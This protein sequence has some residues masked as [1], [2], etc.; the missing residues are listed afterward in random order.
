MNTQYPMIYHDNS[1]VINSIS[2]SGN[3]FY[4]TDGSANLISAGSISFNDWLSAV[5]DGSSEFSQV[6][7]SDPSRTIERY[8]SEVMG[9]ESSFEAFIAWARALR[10]GAWNNGYTAPVVNDWIREGFD[11]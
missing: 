11:K 3:R 1:D 10:K 7:Y 9:G 5:D 6:S 4:K 8:N 2:A